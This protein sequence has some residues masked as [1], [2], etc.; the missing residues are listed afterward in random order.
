MSNAEPVLA[1]EK[2]RAGRCHRCNGCFGLIRHHFASNQFCSKRCVEIY[3]ANIKRRSYHSKRWTETMSGSALLGDQ[4]H[5]RLIME[6]SADLGG[7]WS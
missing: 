7:N 4:V 2:G 3:E 6:R 5:K 1:F